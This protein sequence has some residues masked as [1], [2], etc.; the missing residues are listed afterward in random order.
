MEYA[1]QRDG[2]RRRINLL[3]LSPQLAEGRRVAKYIR[4]S[5][6]QSQ[7]KGQDRFLSGNCGFRFR[8]CCFWGQETG[9]SPTD[10]RKLGSKHNIITDANGIPLA[11][12]ITP[13]NRHDVNEL[14]PLVESVPYV[15]GKP[16]PPRKRPDA[17]Y[18]DRGY[19]SE[20]HRNALREKGIKPV[21]ARRREKHGSGLGIYRWV[22]E[23]TISWLHQFRRLR[24]RYERL[25]E[26]HEAFLK[27]GC[28][29]ICWRSFSNA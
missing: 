28:I 6:R 5:A 22:V 8:A 13:A 10:R 15:F 1:A 17:L 16:G 7:R 12:I 3:D 19:D 29:L 20:P 14:I 4:S 18:A 11:T 2:M 9:P 23:R 21:I 25:S 27:I 24:V 26:I